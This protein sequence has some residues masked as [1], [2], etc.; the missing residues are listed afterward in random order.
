MTL[1]YI[2]HSIVSR[3]QHWPDLQAVMATGQVRLGLS[4]WN[5]FEIAQA[6]DA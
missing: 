4:L 6:T 3:E 2:D 1:L 5:F